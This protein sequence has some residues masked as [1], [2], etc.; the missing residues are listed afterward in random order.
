MMIVCPSC[1]EE[2]P[3]DAKFCEACG[4]D[5]NTEPLPAC[6]ACGEREVAEEGYCLSCGHKQPEERDHLT[7]EAGA[8]V[9]VTDRGKRHRHNEDAVAVAE[10]DG[11]GAVLVVCDGV[12]STS[13]SAEAS[14][15]AAAAARDL[16]V[17]GL[18]PADE[19]GDADPETGEAVSPDVEELLVRAV[20]EAQL[21]AAASAEV[22]DTEGSV[23]A[24]AGVG[25]GAG[26]DG[27]S[28]SSTFVAVVARPADAGI[29]LSTAW[30]GDSRAYWLGE[31]A[32]K[33]TGADHELGGSL[34]R[35]L[36]ADTI[37]ATPDV[38]STVVPNGGHVVVCSDGLWRYAPEP[39]ELSELAGRFLSDG[40]RGVDL[41]SAMVAFANE[42]GGHDNISVALWTDTPD[43][44]AGSDAAGQAVE[45]DADQPVEQDADQ[46]V[47][48]DADNQ[49]DQEDGEQGP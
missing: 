18:S 36:G 3:E 10:L 23:A 6:V 12:S 44:P 5:L 43:T 15:R 40:H 9:A 41:A 33:L 4:H 49:A 14:L 1:G 48:H 28:P 38:V 42:Q 22:P 13:G 21:Q 16:L 47:D 34:V 26:H 19:E 32:E 29:L 30:V 2:A 17:V 24:V 20:G 35:W 8:A 45:Q 31:Q 46:P 11:G 39:E 7:V 25:A 37:N 27:G